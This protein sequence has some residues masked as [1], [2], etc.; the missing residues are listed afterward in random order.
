LQEGHRMEIRHFTECIEQDKP[1]RVQPEESLN[2]QKIID[3]IYLSSERNR[4]VLI[5]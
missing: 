1:V 4:D 3:A 2:V 5:K